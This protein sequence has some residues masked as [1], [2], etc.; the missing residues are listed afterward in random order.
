[1]IVQ[2]AFRL[3][4]GFLALARATSLESHVL[5]SGCAREV[6]TRCKSHY[7]PRSIGEM[8]YEASSRNH[9]VDHSEPEKRH[10]KTSSKRAATRQH[11][12]FSAAMR[13][14][15]YR[16]GGAP[17]AGPVKNAAAPSA[18]ILVSSMLSQPA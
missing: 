6:V 5:F 17:L 16:P 15:A 10:G 7:E 13:R 14:L 1:V 11:L 9:P 4:F 3:A 8:A 18:F 12:C 2:A